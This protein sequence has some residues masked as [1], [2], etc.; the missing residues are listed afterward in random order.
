[1][2]RKH[3]FVNK[4][5]Y[6]DWAIERFTRS[7]F[8]DVLAFFA[9]EEGQAEYEAWEAE[10]A[11]QAELNR[12]KKRAASKAALSV[13]LDFFL[14]GPLGLDVGKIGAPFGKYSCS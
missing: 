2:G 14:R 1:M 10:Q 5:P 8:D 13:Y 3:K 12:T 6:P 9:T 11:K 7:I 4:T